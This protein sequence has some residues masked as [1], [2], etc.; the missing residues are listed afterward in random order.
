MAWSNHMNLSPEALAVHHRLSTDLPFFFERAPILVKN[1]KGDI[2]TFRLNRAQQHIHNCLEKQLRETGRVR[3]L[4][5]KGR[6]E[7]CSLYLTG[8][9]Y[10]KCSRNKG[11]TALLISHDAKATDH[12]FS[13]IKRYQKYVNPV[14]APKEGTANRN[15]LAFSELESSFSVGTAGN[16]DI[17]R[18][19]T[20]QIF[21][22][23]EVAY[24]KNAELIQDGAMQTVPNSAGTEIV[25]ESTANGPVGLFYNMCDAALH[26]KGEY[27][28]IFVPW[29]WMDEYEEPE[30]PG[31]NNEPYTAEEEE[32]C[33][34]NLGEYPP[35]VA[36]RKMLWRRAKIFEFGGSVNMER[37]LR[38][39]RQ[40]YPAN[41]VEAF[42]ASGVGLVSPAAIMA[43]RKN[44]GLSD[45][46]APLIMGV[47]SAGGGEE[48]D[49]TVLAFRRGRVF[50]EFIKVP[51]MPNMD[52]ALAGVVVNEIKKRGVD[53]CFIDVGF[54][55]GTIDRLHELGYRRVV[56]A[57]GFG[58]R[59]LRPDVYM[60][61]RSEMLIEAAEWINGRG[62][63]IP[64][65]DELHSD[66]AA[67]PIDETTSNGLKYIKPKKDIKKLL[68]G[69]STDIF[70]AFALTFAYPVRKNGFGSA[71]NSGAG[72][73]GIGGSDFGWSK[74]DGG[75][76][77]LSS[78]NRDRNM[79]R[80]G[81]GR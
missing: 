37:G 48:S 5:V 52:M 78:R 24:T 16:E 6:Q 29:W 20:H 30:R 76:S 60:N 14:L 15:Q 36:R 21:H 63:R 75:K 9:N 17:G 23:S 22:W 71:R 80:G 56:Q 59:A 4:I 61:K 42:Q 65:S 13:M 72:V 79:G 66:L 11:I 38:K 40:V 31:V 70:D 74:K 32:Y 67:V 54:G 26:G 1:K 81:R 39:F 57:V 43:A 7:G 44:I 2:V 50:E 69:K 34:Q 3:A 46:N 64:D 12:L 45:E 77:P 47:D 73:N 55:H 68:G 18:G 62:V 25:L 49:R 28:L 58:E 8:R 51:K 41:P 33:A 27:Q 10:F 19:G 35:M 53:M